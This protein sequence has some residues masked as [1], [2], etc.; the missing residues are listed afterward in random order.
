MKKALFIIAGLVLIAV[1]LYFALR[2]DKQVVSDKAVYSKAELGLEFV[3]QAGPEGYVVEERIPAD[4]GELVRVIILHRTED[5]LKTPPVGG[6]GPAVMTISV[7][8]NTKKQ[9][10][11]V[12][13]NENIQ[14]SNI[15]LKMG[16]VSE[17]VV[18]GANAIR[19]MAD[20]LYASE[21]VVVAHGENIY[22]FTGQFMDANSDLRSDFAPL[23]DSVKFI[24]KVGQ[25]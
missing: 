3:Y 2:V 23:I 8:N 15:N 1:G 17:D 14:Y 16:D 18:G 11:S 20:G 25:E 22:V 4:L 19:Y 21:N 13:A 12:W 10:P 6:E 24:P 5:T 7:F 9:F